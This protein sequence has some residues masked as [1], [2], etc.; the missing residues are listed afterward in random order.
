MNNEIE[1][2]VIEYKEKLDKAGATFLLV[3]AYKTLVAQQDVCQISS[4]SGKEGIRAILHAI[5]EPTKAGLSVIAQAFHGVAIASIDVAKTA[6]DRAHEDGVFHDAAK[7]LLDRLR[8]HW[9]IKGWETDK[10]KTPPS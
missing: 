1:A 2:L 9:T 8:P 4:N 5:L 7:T 10:L 6:L 3:Y